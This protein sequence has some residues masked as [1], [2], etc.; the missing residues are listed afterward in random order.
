MKKILLITSL[1][2]SILLMGCV[3]QKE[4]SSFEECMK[5]GY[6]IMESYPRQCRVTG[7]PV[8]V[9]DVE[10]HE[11]CYPPKCVPPQGQEYDIEPE[12]L[13]VCEDK[14]G[15]GECAEVVCL[16][17]GCPCAETPETCP[18]DCKLD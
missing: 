5:A 2:F 9:E 4:I 1:F 10:P 6:P 18:E 11:D 15:D 3:I 17:I 14:C 7:G 8:F 12:P 16:A 13:Q